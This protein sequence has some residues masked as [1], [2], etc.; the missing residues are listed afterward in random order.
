MVSHDTLMEQN[1]VYRD[2]WVRNVEVCAECNKEIQRIARYEAEHPAPNGPDPEYLA[3]LRAM[4][5]RTNELNRQSGELR[6]QIRQEWNRAQTE[7]AR[8][9]T[10]FKEGDRVEYFARSFCG[11]GGETV[12]GTVKLYRGLLRV[13]LDRPWHDGRRYIGIGIGWRPLAALEA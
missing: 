9:K 11:I 10:G 13:R 6:K 8:Q 4:Y 7:E 3:T 1:P 12:T 5:H 2:L